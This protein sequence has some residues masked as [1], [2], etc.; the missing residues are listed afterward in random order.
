M[1]FLAK[2]GHLIQSPTKKQFEQVGL[3]VFTNM[4]VPKLLFTSN[5]IKKNWPLDGPKLA[6]WPNIGIFG[7]FGPMADQRTIQCK[8]GA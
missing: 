2:Y 1:A 7:P 6:F 8:Q 3:V 5:K 4:W